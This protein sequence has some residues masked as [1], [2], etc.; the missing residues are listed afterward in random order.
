MLRFTGK[1]GFLN[2]RFVVLPLFLNVFLFNKSWY[3]PVNRS[4]ILILLFILDN[5]KLKEQNNTVIRDN[6]TLSAENVLLTEKNNNLETKKEELMDIIRNDF[7]IIDEL[8]IEIE[9][10]KEYNGILRK[11]LE[12]QDAINKLLLNDYYERHP[13][14][15]NDDSLL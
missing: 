9:N 1:Y 12:K 3:L 10:L 6:Q 5:I 4:L 7:K 2:H 11:A 15:E 8:K 13:K 14:G